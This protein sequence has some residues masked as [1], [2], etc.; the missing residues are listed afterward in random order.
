[1]SKNKLFVVGVMALIII[2]LYLVFSVV[3]DHGHHEHG[4]M[5]KIQHNSLDSLPFERNR[6]SDYMETVQHSS[7]DSIHNFK[8][9][10]RAHQLTS[11]PCT[12]C[13]TKSIDHM[14]K[15]HLPGKKK[16]HWD[17]K[18]VHAGED[19]MNC[20]TC[21]NSDSPDQL[22]S[23]TGND[24]SFDKAFVLCGQCHSTQFKEW[25]GGAHGKRMTGWKSERVSTSCVG[26]HNPHQ[27]AFEK[28]WPS[29]YNTKSLVKESD[30]KSH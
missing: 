23:L 10:A 8:V 2:G 19:A 7:V 16:A 14:K 13:H 29:R 17:V 24:I 26:C 25:E 28:R 18:L 27:P 11:F 21:H 22:K 6:E 3:P 30:A 20:Q 15:D 12:S 5:S 4:I 1:M 9:G